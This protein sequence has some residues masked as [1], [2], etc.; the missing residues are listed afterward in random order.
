MTF[1]NE[2]KA[3]IKDILLCEIL[4]FHCTAVEVFVLLWCYPRFFL[5]ILTLKD[6]NDTLF[7]KVSTEVSNDTA[8]H[9]R[10][11]RPHIMLQF[12]AFCL[13]H[14]IKQSIS[15]VPGLIKLIST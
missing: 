3:T 14:G 9:P 7:Q 4:G 6:V 12:A 5:A 13:V 15:Y 10:R 11:L 2:N 1:T 8:Q